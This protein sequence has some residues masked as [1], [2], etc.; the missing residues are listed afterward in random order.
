MPAKNI[1]CR[2]EQYQTCPNL[3]QRGGYYSFQRKTYYEIK[4]IYSCDTQGGIYLLECK[5]CG[6]QYIGESSTTI[7]IRMRHHRN[8]MQAN[9]NRPIYRH[10]ISHQST[11]NIYTITIID[12]VTNRMERKEKERE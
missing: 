2:N 6:K 9:S 8:A 10:V 5:V 1:K 12:Q 4:G 11:F 7:R 3:T